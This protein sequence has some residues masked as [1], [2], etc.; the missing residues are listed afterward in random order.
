MSHRIISILMWASLAT[1]A[2]LCMAF[3]NYRRILSWSALL[4]WPLLTLAESVQLI[5]AATDVMPIH[6]RFTGYAPRG[7]GLR[8][9]G[10]EGVRP[11]YGE[12][13]LRAGTGPGAEFGV[14][15][16]YAPEEMAEGSAYAGPLRHRAST[17]T[18]AQPYKD[19][20]RYLRDRTG[21]RG[22]VT[23]PREKKL[24]REEGLQGEGLR[25]QP[26][27]EGGLIEPREGVVDERDETMNRGDAYRDQARPMTNVPD[28]VPIGHRRYVNRQPIGPVDTAAYP[29]EYVTQDRDWNPE[30]RD[31]YQKTSGPYGGNYWDDDFNDPNKD[32]L[33]RDKRR[34]YRDHDYEVDRY[35]RPKKGGMFGWLFGGKQNPKVAKDFE[36]NDYEYNRPG[37]SSVGTARAP[38]SGR[39]I[40]RE[41]PQEEA[42]RMMTTRSKMR[43]PEGF[44]SSPGHRV[45][46][47]EEERY[48][49]GRVIEEE[50]QPKRRTR[51][52]GKVV[53]P[54]VVA[55]VIEEEEIVPEHKLQKERIIPQR[56][57]LEERFIPSKTEYEEEV[58]PEKRAI[59]RRVIAEKQP[60]ILEGSSQ[61]VVPVEEQ[62]FV[63]EA[64]SR[65]GKTAKGAKHLEREVVPVETETIT[66]TTTTVEEGKGLMGKGATYIDEGKGMMGKG[67]TYIDEGKG[68]MGKGTTYVDEG[69]GLMGKGTTTTT[70]DEGKGMTGKTT[71]VLDEG[72]GTTGKTVLGAKKAKK[73]PSLMDKLNTAIGR[74]HTTASGTTVTTTD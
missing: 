27:E 22:L 45:V 15:K 51:I 62:R 3:F 7:E 34:D 6:Q 42:P 25:G 67:T 23:A 17:L 49:P 1:T 69:K 65:L 37:L 26:I 35:G 31:F 18:E 59:E 63:S 47:V 55:N 8:G 13:G 4:F 10:E 57:V 2:L 48:L 54:R 12:E 9:Y 43:L 30:D 11:A 20:D 28:Q 64:P 16:G 33:G 66:T 38:S 46:E 56:R 60:R 24:A 19:R 71:T 53:E 50:A 5:L 29:T 70:I 61:R 44:V 21:L 52:V 74:D 39:I 36:T 32:W 68:M 58:I 40:E 41:V 14:G 73:T 72:K